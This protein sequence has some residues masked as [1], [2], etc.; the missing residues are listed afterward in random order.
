MAY[1]PPCLWHSSSDRFSYTTT[2]SPRLLPKRFWL[3]S[4][5]RS[6]C[7]TGTSNAE[8]TLTDQVPDKTSGSAQNGRV[9]LSLFPRLRSQSNGDSWARVAVP[10]Q[11]S[12]LPVP[13]HITHLAVRPCPVPSHSRQRPVPPQDAHLPWLCGMISIRSIT[14]NSLQTSDSTPA[15]LTGT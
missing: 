14:P 15:A 13:K 11:R 10:P 5:G 9:S 1:S 6:F 2:N 8:K 7:F 4:P 12:H 3:L